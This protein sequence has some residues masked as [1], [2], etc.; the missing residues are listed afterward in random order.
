M[1][2]DVGFEKNILLN[3]EYMKIYI[4]YC[5]DF[6]GVNNILVL[7]CDKDGDIFNMNFFDM[8]KNVYDQL[9]FVNGV[10]CFLVVLFFFF[11]M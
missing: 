7:V 8:L 4:E 1:C 10:N 6:G 11:F 9:F 2:L 3:Y 5:K